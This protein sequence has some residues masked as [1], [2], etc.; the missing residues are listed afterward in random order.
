MQLGCAGVVAE[1]NERALAAFVDPEQFTDAMVEGFLERLGK[2]RTGGRGKHRD[3]VTNLPEVASFEVRLGEFI[4]AGTAPN[5]VMM[6]ITN[7]SDAQGRTDRHAIDLL[8]RRLANSYSDAAR[9]NGCEVF[10]LGQAT[11]AVLDGAQHL[12]DIEPFARDLITI[13]EAFKPA[14]VKLRLAVGAVTAK[15][16]SEVMA[17]REQA[18]QAM[19]AAAQADESAFVTAEQVTVLLASSTEYQV[20]EQLARRVDAQ[21]PYPDGHSA[22]VADLAAGIGREIGYQGRELSSLRL[23]ALLHD[24]GKIASEGTAD[25]GGAGSDFAE[26]GA[27]YVLAGAGPEVADA[28]R[29]QTERWDGQGPNGLAE[30]DIPLGARIICI[31]DT[32]DGWL[33]PPEGTDALT[34]DA[35]VEQIGNGSGS[36]FDP[37]LADTA[38]R[39]LGGS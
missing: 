6:Q 31:A 20:A 3:P 23:A 34:P 35:L 38:L 4:E 9:R 8:R 14:G 27:R 37:A 2:S 28:I 12:V 11:F 22:R 19:T 36:V 18:D 10:I 24:V 1:G 15:A 32:T 33:H 26:R 25:S 13:T 21:L 30:G 16:G 7:I 39:L 29:Y 17:I 5:V